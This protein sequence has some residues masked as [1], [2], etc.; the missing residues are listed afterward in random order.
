MCLLRR[1]VCDTGHLIHLSALDEVGIG[2]PERLARSKKAWKG[3]L[4]AAQQRLRHV[5]T[6][7]HLGFES[8]QGTAAW[9]RG[10]G[11][12]GGRPRRPGSAQRHVTRILLVPEQP[13]G[14]HALQLV[15][16]H[17]GVVVP[18]A[19]WRA[20]VGR[21]AC[22][23]RPRCATRSADALRPRCMSPATA[24]G[25]SGT[26]SERHRAPSSSGPSS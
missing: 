5:P 9:R 24:Q 3:S 25:C 1:S 10:S 15:V 20:A 17:Q 4:Q 18:G 13:T 22:R 21:A 6:R 8:V 14:A 7:P 16:Q 12:S 19:T 11:T 23:A 2:V 26:S